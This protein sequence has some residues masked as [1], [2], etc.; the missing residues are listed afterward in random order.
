MKH[1]P[2][3]SKVPADLATPVAAQSGA[4]AMISTPFIDRYTDNHLGELAIMLS[5]EGIW[6]LAP[7]VGLTVGDHGDGF[8]M[9]L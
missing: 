4:C 6:E 5:L 3:I 8:G 9:I 2:L 7:M 1:Y